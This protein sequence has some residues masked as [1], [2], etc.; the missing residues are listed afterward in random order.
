[1]AGA[2]DDIVRSGDDWLDATKIMTGGFTLAPNAA[3]A[4]TDIV[5]QSFSDFAAENAA[6]QALLVL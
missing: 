1:M 5:L 2:G 3:L 6:T 4:V